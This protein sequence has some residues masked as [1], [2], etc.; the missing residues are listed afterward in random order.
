MIADKSW[1]SLNITHFLFR[2]GLEYKNLKEC[3][4]FENNLAG[5]MATHQLGNA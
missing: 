2:K 1:Y 3:I 4:D 5:Q